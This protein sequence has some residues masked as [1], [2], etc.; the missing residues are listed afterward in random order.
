L[1]RDYELAGANE[2][3][4]GLE[5]VEANLATFSEDLR[6]SAGASAG[7]AIPREPLALIALPPPRLLENATEGLETRLRRLNE[8]ATVTGDPLEKAR[9]DLL[10]RRVQRLKAILDSPERVRFSAERA[11][12]FSRIGSAQWAS[13][14]SDRQGRSDARFE[15]ALRELEAETGYREIFIPPGTVRGPPDGLSDLV[16]SSLRAYDLDPVQWLRSEARIRALEAELGGVEG[17]P[18]ASP[19]TSADYCRVASLLTDG[20]LDYY[21]RMVKEFHSESTDALSSYLFADKGNHQA[22]WLAALDGEIR[23]REKGATASVRTGTVGALLQQYTEGERLSSPRA[24]AQFLQLV[25][26]RFPHVETM[27]HGARREVAE[28]LGKMSVEYLDAANELVGRYREVGDR[29]ARSTAITSAD[30]TSGIVE[31]RGSLQAI[32]Q[33]LERTLRQAERFGA[34]VSKQRETGAAL[35]AI[36]PADEW[37][38]PDPDS[39]LPPSPPGTGPRRP[40]PSLAEFPRPPP[41]VERTVRRY[42]PGL[43]KDLRRAAQYLDRAEKRLAAVE[44]G[45]AHL[46]T[47]PQLIGETKGRLRVTEK[48]VLSGTS[49]GERNKPDLAVDRLP[50]QWAGRL[51]PKGKPYPFDQVKAPT[52]FEPVGGGIH[53]GETAKYLGSENLRSAALTYERGVGLILRDGPS[54]RR[55]VVPGTKDMDPTTLKALYRFVA[56]GRNAAVSIGWG[57]ERENVFAAMHRRGENAVLLDPYLIDTAV[58]QALVL[59]DAV[60]WRL[61]QPAI[62]NGTAIPFHQEFARL[63]LQYRAAQRQALR[64]LVVANPQGQAGSSDC[65]QLGPAS[66]AFLSYVDFQRKALDLKFEQQRPQLELA[67]KRQIGEDPEVALRWAA[68]NSEQRQS[69]MNSFLGQRLKELERDLEADYKKRWS[70]GGDFRDARKVV[71]PA[72]LAE[73]MITPDSPNRAFVECWVSAEIAASRP[74][75]DVVADLLA[76]SNPLTLAVLADHEVEFQLSPSGDV[77]LVTRLE[78]FYGTSFVEVT[79]NHVGVAHSPT[80]PKVDVKPLSELT[81]LVNR[82]IAL[83]ETYRPLANIREYAGIAAFL[84]WAREAESERKLGLVD[85]SALGAVASNDPKR[86][87]TVD[88]LLRE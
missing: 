20:Q 69:S 38:P 43:E 35:F 33:Q 36:L 2:D 47:A 70:R 37:H 45:A 27:P 29:L 7:S 74:V 15:R 56:A 71:L 40:G 66:A 41:A 13:L 80:N 75:D 59:A 62:P 46:E 32:A 68:M 77:V 63:Q 53:F 39:P 52:R 22:L 42:Q 81:S 55:W 58:G 12:V 5:R 9:R 78:Y 14:S 57:S 6:T 26:Y 87:R 85:L 84:R 82:H 61:D 18:A 4:E 23:R 60:P 88:A 28:I 86:H 50:M 3:L 24:E 73:S 51:D 72:F 76:F 31:A 8:L 44:A 49:A 10:S 11:R 83:L 48:S 25:T 65:R 54:R 16:F 67:I 17:L 21:R 64:E 79:S 34:D 19:G 30:V 1:A